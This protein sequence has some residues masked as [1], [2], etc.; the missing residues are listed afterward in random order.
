MVNYDQTWTKNERKI[1]CIETINTGDRILKCII[2]PSLKLEKAQFSK[3][4]LLNIKFKQS[5]SI[6]KIFFTIR[7]FKI[8]FNFFLIFNREITLYTT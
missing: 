2:S 4:K 8:F 7:N 6:L 5:F 1:N 3:L